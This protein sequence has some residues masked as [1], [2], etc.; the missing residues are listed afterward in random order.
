MTYADTILEK[1]KKRLRETS[2]EFNDEILDYINAAVENLK[3]AGVHESHF[4]VA[5]PIDS[6]LLMAIGTYCLAKFGLYN[7]DSE[8]Y[9]KSY[10]SQRDALC[11]QQKYLRSL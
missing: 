1:V 2:N 10:C 6:E 3:A 4:S 5:K 8:K 9:E 7:D 11:V